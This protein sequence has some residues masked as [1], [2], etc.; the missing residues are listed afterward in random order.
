MV[1][2]DARGSGILDAPD[3]FTE[4]LLQA[5]L[6][7][8]WR[9]TSPAQTH[10]NYDMVAAEDHDEKFYR[11]FVLQLPPTFAIT[12][13]DTTWD[14]RFPKLPLQRK[15]LHMAIWDSI[16]WNLRPLLLRQPQLLPA[17]KSVMLC[18]QKRKIAAAALHSL[19]AATHL[20]VLLGSCHT[21]AAA[22]ISST[23]EA[24]VIFVYLVTD[25]VLHDH[26]RQQ[27]KHPHQQQ[28]Q[29]QQQQQALSPIALE[30]PDPLEARMGRVTHTACAAAIKA[31][32]RRLQMLA[33]ASNLA[34][35]A[36][37]VLSQLLKVNNHALG[38]H[39]FGPS[40]IAMVQGG[41]S[42]SGP[43]LLTESETDPIRTTH[44][45]RGVVTP[46]T[47]A[48]MN[49]DN[50]ALIHSEMAAISTMNGEMASWPHGSPADLG[51]VDDLIPSSPTVA[52]GDILD[53]TSFE[54]SIMNAQEADVWV[55]YRRDGPHPEWKFSLSGT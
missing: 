38:S 16:C 6:A 54:A 41:R 9:R 31:A 32:L 51:L 11:E 5:D 26:Q 29:Q 37:N 44:G 45:A 23:F 21:R 10:A 42:F 17:Y 18:C 53:W 47:S 46:T 27:Q 39:F 14:G 48:T 35:V 24:A 25:P 22:I 12:E 20:H 15:L 4:R 33:E 1:S 34:E 3:P 7:D 50:I 8:F 52:G 19:E 28:Q 49:R 30:E 40:E 13:P 43:S 2:D 55:G 36:A